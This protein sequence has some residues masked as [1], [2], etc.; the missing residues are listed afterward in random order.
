MSFSI[1]S[2]LLS[3]FQLQSTPGAPQINL[4]GY[5]RLIT[6]TLQLINVV[7]MQCNT[8]AACSMWGPQP[9]PLVTACEATAAGASRS[10]FSTRCRISPPSLHLPLCDQLLSL[11]AYIPFFFILFTSF[12]SYLKTGRIDLIPLSL[13][14]YR[15]SG[16]IT[17]L[18]ANN[19][20][21]L[22]IF[23]CVSYGT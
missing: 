9:S 19:Y 2:A 20:N 6:S 14:M 8:H 7:S 11:P 22:T 16:A 1:C 4:F 17:F 23:H 3:F 10:G 18:L 12:P 5:K 13:L 15:T 21:K